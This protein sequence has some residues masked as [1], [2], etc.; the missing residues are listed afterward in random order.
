MNRV[1]ETI[2]AI[3][4]NGLGRSGTILIGVADK[5]ADVLRIKQLDDIEPYPVGKRSVVGIQREARAL[6]ESPEE[7]FARWKEVIRSSGLSRPLRDSVLANI[8]YADYFGYGVVV[9][10]VPSQRDVSLVGE[11]I[12][13]RTGDETTQVTE[14]SRMLEIGKRFQGVV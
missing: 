7:Y 4:N 3:A 11:K 9:I 8:S 12:F 6:G 5:P 13:I 10:K 1:V 14:A 2:C